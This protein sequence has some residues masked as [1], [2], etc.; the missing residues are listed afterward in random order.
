MVASKPMKIR[1]AILSVVK[2]LAISTGLVACGGQHGRLT[3][4]VPVLPYQ[5][6]DISEITG[7][8]EPDEADGDGSGSAEPGK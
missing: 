3:V 7:I 6:P 8:P 5:P 2:V 4:D 1:A